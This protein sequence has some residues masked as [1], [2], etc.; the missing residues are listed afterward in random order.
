MPGPARHLSLSA[1]GLRLWVALGT[2]ATHVAVLD[3]SAARQ[4]TARADDPA[5]VSRARRRLGARGRACLG[6]VGRRAPRSRS[7]RAN[8]RVPM[9]R[10]PAG[11]APQHVA[12]LGSRAYVASGEDGSVQGARP[13]R[14]RRCGASVRVPVG[15]YNISFDGPAESFA[16]PVGVTPSLDRGTVCLLSPSGAVRHRPDAWPARPTTPA[17]SRPADGVLDDHEEEVMTMKILTCAARLL[18]PPCVAAAAGKRRGEGR[19]VPRSRSS[20]G[21][22]SGSQRRRCATSRYPEAPRTTTVAGVRVNG[23][24][25]LLLRH[26][27]RASSVSLRSRGTE[28]PD[29]I[30]ANGRRLVLASIT[31]RRRAA[32]RRPSSC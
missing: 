9:L 6:D 25:V 23:G 18:R 19:A 1:D 17:S 5:A 8:A 32:S 26:G 3:V 10:L 2:K 22:A 15:S 27:T 11:S 24:R 29:G 31:S 12:F 16:K 13:R 30:S 4:P 28:R 14:Q 21:T 20:A 7:T